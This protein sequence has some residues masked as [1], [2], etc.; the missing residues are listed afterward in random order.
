M[1][2]IY[3][4]T[5]EDMIATYSLPRLHSASNEPDRNPDYR[6]PAVYDICW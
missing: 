1:A 3:K 2:K 4:P 5:K 6:Q